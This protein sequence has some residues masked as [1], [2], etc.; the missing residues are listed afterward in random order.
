M[1]NLN[2][3]NIDNSVLVGFAYN[4]NIIETAKNSAE[5]EENFASMT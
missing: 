3:P 1:L 5:V 4:L 2:V